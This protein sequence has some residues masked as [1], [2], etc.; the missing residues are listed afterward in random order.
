L[1]LDSPPPYSTELR[2]T[3]VPSSRSLL[4]I[5]GASF[6]GG[7]RCAAMH[8]F[9]RLAISFD[10]PLVWKTAEVTDS[11][12]SA[13]AGVAAIKVIGKR[14][15]NFAIIGATLCDVVDANQPHQP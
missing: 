1:P 10:E 5:S 14:R 2:A 7:A 9:A 11:S 15:M 8:P 12:C 6:F 4:T 3:I 13:A